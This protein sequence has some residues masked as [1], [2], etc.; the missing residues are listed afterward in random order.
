MTAALFVFQ[1]C[2]GTPVPP[3]AAEDEAIVQDQEN[4]DQTKN[5]SPVVETL[6]E[7]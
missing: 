6:P 3:A 4:S 1:A 2:Y 7:K 5:E